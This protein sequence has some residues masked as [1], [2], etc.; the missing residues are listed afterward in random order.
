MRLESGRVGGCS[1]VRRVPVEIL[2]VE[3]ASAYGRF[4]G[5]PSRAELERYFLLD[6]VDRSLVMRR[7]GEAN[8]VGL[9]FR[10]A[11]FGCSARS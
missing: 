3:Q 1:T 4:V 11:S 9:R 5:A 6:D 8:R 10:S 7:R 2:T